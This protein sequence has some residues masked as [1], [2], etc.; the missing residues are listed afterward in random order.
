[1]VKNIL[2]TGAPGVGK[3]T[4]VK[5]LISRLGR[6]AL[7]GFYTE[8]VREASARIGFRAVTLSGRTA[9]FAHRDFH[10]ESRL[11]VGRY[12]VK[13]EVLEGLLL[14]YLNPLQKNADLLIIDEIARM[15]LLSPALREN[16][17]QALDS[18]V[19]VLATISLKGSGIIKRI[20]S[21]PDVEVIQT[22]RS[23]REVIGEQI[24]RRLRQ[25]LS[26]T[27][28]A[29]ETKDREAT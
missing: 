18:A 17:W 15:E 13:P 20:K 27:A 28:A 11:R 8:E 21:R 1:M 10:V 6:F 4:L 24:L 3:T 12:G 16:I 5:K 26:T 2:L 23:N 19:P 7:K 25:I 29:P 14:P 9:I 22:T